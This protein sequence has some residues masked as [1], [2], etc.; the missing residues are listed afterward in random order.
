VGDSLVGV[1]E[2][3]NRG[4][5]VAK[6]ATDG[7]LPAEA[8]KQQEPE[9]PAEPAKAEDPKQEP[10]KRRP[11]ARKPRSKAAATV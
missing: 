2:F 9:K 10:A 6:L 8:P 3:P 5:A 1:G 4:A 11:P 7:K